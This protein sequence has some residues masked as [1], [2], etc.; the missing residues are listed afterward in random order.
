MSGDYE[1]PKWLRPTEY[2]DDR[3]S[4]EASHGGNSEPEGDDE[5]EDSPPPRRP[6]RD[7]RRGSD[8]VSNDT[9]PLNYRSGNPDEVFGDVED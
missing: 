7:W 8:R 5:D 6:G 1:R 9:E 2:N 3:F 4:G